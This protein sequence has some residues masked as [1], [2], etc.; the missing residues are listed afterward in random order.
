M[1]EIVTFTPN[2]AVDVSACVERVVPTRKLR[3]S[4]QR[5]DPGGGGINVARVIK[6]MGADVMAVFTRGG[7]TGMLLSK[8]IECEGVTISYS[9]IAEETREDFSIYEESTGNQYRFVLPG[10]SLTAYE[11]QACLDRLASLTDPPPRFVIGS[12]S[13]PP[14]APADLYARAGNIAKARN[15]KFILD[16]SGAPL[17][18]ALTRGVYLIK[19]NLREL[20]ELAGEQLVCEQDW[21]G[22]AKRIVERREAEVVALTLGH[23]GALL[24]S[25][26]MVLRAEALPIEPL[27]AVGAGDSFLGA[28]TWALA[29]GKS[30]EDAF[31]YG[32]AAGSSA[33][34]HPGTELCRADNTRELVPQVVIRAL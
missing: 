13:L 22:A 6:R 19:P 29:A 11:W 27:S 18:A 16:T 3:C 14:G 25:K 12:G 26:D 8:L 4:A 32:V 21:V 30:L 9:E 17:V 1:T 33:L 2:P 10:P 34:L 28:M 15:A 31:R 7:A 23:R 24:V 5:R 20:S